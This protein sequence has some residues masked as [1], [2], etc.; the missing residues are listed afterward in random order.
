MAKKRPPD[1]LSHYRAKRSLERT[2]EP[3]GVVARASGQLFVVHKHAARR[4]HYDLRLEMD[5]VLR[6]WAVPK[7]P[8]F[9][10][11]EKRLAV[12]VEDHPIE[13][14]DFE[15]RIP[16]GNY[17]AGAVIVWDR[18]QWIPVSDPGEGLAKGKL[19]FELRGYKLRGM[20]TLVKIKKAEKEWLLI[21]ERDGWATADPE[22]PPAESVLSGL[23]V[24]DLGAG[25]DRGEA[26]RSELVR[27]GAARKPVETKSA[28]PMLAQSAERPFSGPGW[29][30]EPK[31][32][33]YRVVAARE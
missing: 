32:D 12:F 9:D 4:L 13:Y 14:G 1:P 8:S 19:L 16:E 2:P 3:A 23:T 17:G 33:G 31:L 22:E 18:G 29:R 25:R 7:G 10:P 21:K 24:E 28:A 26:I 20:W 6:S 30:F 27:L 5:G 11:A 15:G